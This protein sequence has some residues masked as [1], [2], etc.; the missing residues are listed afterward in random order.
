MSEPTNP[1][2]TSTLAVLAQFAADGFDENH[3]VTDR[4]DV[5]CGACATT[6]HTE[7]WDIGAQHRVE[8]ASDPDDL[9]LVVGLACPQ[10]SAR[11]AVVA[12]YG[13]TGSE[14]D[15]LFVKAL[16]LAGVQDP[17]A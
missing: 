17:L 15:T 9:Q 11:G 12:A 1:A 5:T 14:A 6:A 3:L 2:D 4:G 8:G 13:P 10:C 16:D 7:S